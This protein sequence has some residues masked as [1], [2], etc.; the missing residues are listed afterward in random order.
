MTRFLPTHYYDRSLPQTF[1]ADESGS[2]ADTLAYPTQQALGLFATPDIATATLGYERVWIV[3]FCHAIDEYR[4]TGYVDHTHRV[5]LEQ[6]HTLVSVTSFGDLE[7]A[8][9]G[10]SPTAFP[11][12]EPDQ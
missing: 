10:L 7:V 8:E 1:I 4:T 5:W 9:S 6:H 2:P 3:I 11:Q 12:L